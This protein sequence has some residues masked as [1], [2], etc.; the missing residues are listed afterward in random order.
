M[1]NFLK[2][3]AVLMMV[4]A[5]TLVPVAA[6]D[7]AVE[8]TADAAVEVEKE[9]IPVELPTSLKFA[10]IA[11]TSSVASDEALD[12]TGLYDLDANTV[13]TLAKDATVSITA[14]GKFRL[15]NFLV[16]K[17]DADF[18][19]YAS[20]DGENWKKLTTKSLDKDNGFL[21]VDVRGLGRAYK[22]YKLEIIAE[23]DVTLHTMVPTVETRDSIYTG[24]SIAGFNANNDGVVKYP[25]LDL[26]Q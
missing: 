16:N 18:A 21:E 14:A 2:R 5:M 26:A 24:F 4:A 6:E 15:A 7:A 20:D 25:A 9:V 19:I 13:V 1:K 3:A 8:V 23:E 10:P 11:V 12:V 17:I 22:F